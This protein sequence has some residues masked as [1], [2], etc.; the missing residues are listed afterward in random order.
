M[1]AIPN[2]SILNIFIYSENHYQNV[3][4]NCYM[5]NSILHS[6]HFKLARRQILIL[7]ILNQQHK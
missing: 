1:Y 4:M 3:K 7:C 6:V 5:D 2:A